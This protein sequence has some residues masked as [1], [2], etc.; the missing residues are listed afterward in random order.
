MLALT[1][2]IPLLLVRTL[3]YKLNYILLLLILLT[4]L[5]FCQQVSS[6]FTTFILKLE[7][8]FDEQKCKMEG[9]YLTKKRSSA[10]VCYPTHSFDHSVSD[11]ETKTNYLNPPQLEH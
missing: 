7:R 5:L 9:I 10:R 8:D 11:R 1:C 4:A 2:N 3:V 6:T